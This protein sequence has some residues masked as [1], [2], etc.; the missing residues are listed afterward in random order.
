MYCE[1]KFSAIDHGD[2]EHIKPKAEGKYPELTYVWGNLG[3][4][5]TKCNGAKS[6]KFDA[7]TPYINPYE[8][9]PSDYIVAEYCFV[10]AKRGN[11]RGKLTIV[12]LELNRAEL[13]E[14]RQTFLDRIMDAVMT[15]ENTK[16]ETLK[17]LAINALIDNASTSGEFSMA[18]TARLAT[19]GIAA[20]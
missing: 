9:N 2:I 14:K 13:V 3:I 1:S 6:D 10:F 8:E 4:S 15:V 19:H 20:A 7:D 18:V 12:D 5:C 16:N 11:E 17:K